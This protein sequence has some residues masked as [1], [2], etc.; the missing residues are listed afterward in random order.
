M[1]RPMNDIR[2][3]GRVHWVVATYSA[4]LC[5][6]HGVWVLVHMNWVVVAYSVILRPMCWI[7]VYV[8]NHN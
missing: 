5:H 3:V 2:V 7:S 8:H 4:M 1:F 6:V